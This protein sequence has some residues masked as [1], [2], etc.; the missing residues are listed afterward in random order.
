MDYCLEIDNI[1]DARLD[2]VEDLWELS[3]KFLETVQNLTIRQ[4]NQELPPILVDY[5]SHREIIFAM[6]ADM[7][8]L[9]DEL[10]IL[11]KNQQEVVEVAFKKQTAL[12]G[13]T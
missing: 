7:D 1:R 3:Q 6:I 5:C 9:E 8:K 4:A 13:A 10:I 12:L 11:L 2:L